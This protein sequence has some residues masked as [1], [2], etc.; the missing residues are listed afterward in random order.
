[1]VSKVGYILRKGYAHPGEILVLAFAKKAQEELQQRIEERFAVQLPVMTFHSLGLSIIG[2]AENRKPSL[3]ALAEQEAKLESFIEVCIDETF[4]DAELRTSVE[5]FFAYYLFP[6]KTAF[7]FDDLTSY[8]EYLKS[9]DLKTLKNERV[10]GFGELCVANFLFLNGIDYEYEAPYRAEDTASEEKRQYKPDFFL[11]G[12]D[13]YIEHFGIDRK[14]GTAPHINAST[15]RQGMEWKRSV[16]ERNETTLIETYHYELSEGKLLSEL[17]KKLL[18]SGVQFTPIGV[19]ELKNH[20]ETLGE[21]RLLTVLIKTFLN[22][23]KSQSQ[24]LPSLVDKSRSLPDRRRTQTFLTLFEA[25]YSRYSAHLERNAS[26]DFHDM[27]RI[28]TEHVREKRYLSPFKYIIVDEFQ[29]ISA[30]RSELI[31]EMLSN[32]SD[33]RLSCVGDDWQSIYRFA[34]SD[35]RFMTEFGEHFGNFAR[36]DLDTTFRFNSGI[37]GASNR[38]VMANE[39][40][41]KK[42]LKSFH[43]V[44]FP[45]IHIMSVNADEK[46]WAPVHRSLG[47]IFEKSDN[48]EVLILARYRHLLAELPKDLQDWFPSLRITM[49]TAHASKGLEADYVIAVGLVSGKYGFPTEIVDDPILEILFPGSAGGMNDEERRLFYVTMTRA[50]HEVFLITDRSSP[51]KFIGE[52]SEGRDYHQWV[53]IEPTDETI[54]TCRVCG[55]PLVERKTE[56]GRFW[57]CSNY[58]YCSGRGVTCPSCEIGV[59]ALKGST[60]H[61]NNPSCDHV[62]EICPLPGCGGFLLPKT[63]RFGP[64]WGCS[65]FPDCSHTRDR[66]EIPPKPF[67]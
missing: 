39:N 45:P 58:P 65:N 14:G 6:F 22:L 2:Q 3:D 7:D 29:D 42:E 43:S 10:K 32:G 54:P 19:D 36:V 53:E 25:V 34:G 37:L 33:T 26:I 8:I 12:N 35:V 20:L 28:A 55:A 24:D 1:V 57:G 11:P 38:F 5:A 21:I 30:L 56:N 40:Q 67:H 62:A 61:C 63:G 27:I 9:H 31:H 47:R 23:F 52:L 51:S 4:A 50:R 13:L 64:F 44:E 16:H 59:L 60:G 17:K 49:M 46:S 18:K 41:L 48:A 66:V 15:Y